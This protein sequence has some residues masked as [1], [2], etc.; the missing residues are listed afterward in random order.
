MLVLE[1]ASQV[2]ETTPIEA[3]PHLLWPAIFSLPIH[4]E[5]SYNQEL[6]AL[7][8]LF[9]RK[10]RKE[11]E[12][13]AGQRAKALFVESFNEFRQRHSRSRVEFLLLFADRG[14]YPLMQLL[15]AC[16]RPKE[17]LSFLPPLAVGDGPRSELLS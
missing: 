13:G 4:E 15:E 7:F 3:L 11:D 14:L 10:L 5:T 1:Y 6:G 9:H 17:G 12:A 2:M 16:D 8:N